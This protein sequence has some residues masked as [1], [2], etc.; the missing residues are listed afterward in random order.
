MVT[1]NEEIT[2]LLFYNLCEVCYWQ[3]NF[4]LCYWTVQ[5][6]VLSVSYFVK[7]VVVYLVH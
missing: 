7:H 5:K 6:Q 3:K 2:F 4:T 1:I